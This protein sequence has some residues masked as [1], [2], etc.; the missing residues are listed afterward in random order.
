MLYT[1]T[2]SDREVYPASRALVENFAPDG[3][4][5]VPVGLK[6]LPEEALEQLLS[7]EE[8]ALLA[9]LMNLFFDSGLSRMDVEFALDKQLSRLGH[10]SHRITVAEGWRNPEGELSWIDHRLFKLVSPDAGEPGQ[11]LRVMTRIW[12]VARTCGQL[13]RENRLA[14]G[15][16]L[17][18]AAVT[19]DFTGPLGAWY[20]RQ[21]G[22][23][24]GGIV[25]CC[26]ENDGFWQLLQS[27]KIRT[28]VAPVE[29]RIPQCDVVCPGGLEQILYAR[30]GA[31]EA[32]RFAAACQA[33]EE[34]QVER[35]T[36][37]GFSASVTYDRRIGQVISNVHATNGYILSATGALLHAGLMDYRGST[38]SRA[39]A[40][41]LCESS[42]VNSVDSVCAA[43]GLTAGEL[44]ARLEQM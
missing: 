43:L 6:K 3:G 42:P 37:E 33:G 29:T 17:D 34:Y 24:V 35:G 9:E 16:K 8:T 12:L 19:G 1:S 5:Y 25:C 39:P 38:G 15:E 26:N 10:M 14:P 30:L 2:R 28:G 27:G 32:R 31:R 36:L 20:A 44:S 21:M 22:F 23:P 7:L 18:V 13:R 40:M 11:W 41:L 4:Y